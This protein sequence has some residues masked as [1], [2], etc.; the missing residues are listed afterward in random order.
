MWRDSIF[1]EGRHGEDENEGGDEEAGVLT[2][3]I[4]P[5]SIRMSKVP[6]D[7]REEGRMIEKK[8]VWITVEAH[9][10]LRQ[11]A[12]ERRITMKELLSELILEN[13]RTMRD[14]QADTDLEKPTQPK[15]EEFGGVW[16]I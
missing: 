14:V 13:I 9:E 3:R 15:R 11:A 1:E 7:N 16:T 4:S 10:R 2:S 12:F 8:P 5:S 6:E